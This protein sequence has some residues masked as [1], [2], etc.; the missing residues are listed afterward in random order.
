MRHA[1]QTLRR[2]PRNAREMEDCKR[3]KED[4][5]KKLGQQQK[6][7]KESKTE[8]WRR[9]DSYRSRKQGKEEVQKNMEKVYGAPRKRK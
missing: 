3:E 2:K 4:Q 5:K 6:Q 1:K 7:C 9:T 8:Q